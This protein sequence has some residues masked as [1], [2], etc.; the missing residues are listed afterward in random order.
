MAR[1]RR[2]KKPH[3]DLSGLPASRNAYL[4][5]AHGQV[6]CVNFPTRLLLFFLIFGLFLIP[7]IA[8]TAYAAW[9]DSN[10]A[11]RK[12]ITID[13][14]QIV[15]GPHTD[16]PVLIS[17]TDTDLSAARADGWD[18]LFTLD[19]GTSKLSHEI[20]KFDNGT[21]E[22]V[23]WVKIP[24]PGLTN[25]SDFTLYLYYGYATVPA[26]Q[27]D[28][29]NVWSNGY[30]GVWHLDETPN[31]GTA[32][33]HDD[34]TGNVLNN[35]GTPQNFQDGD[36]GTTS[37]TG[38]IA[39]ADRFANQVDDA[40]SVA[41]NAGQTPSGDMSFS[42]WVNIDA[43]PNSMMFMQKNH[44]T[45]PWFAYQLYLNSSGW[46]FM[47]WVNSGGTEYN[48]YLNSPLSTGGWHYL[49]GMLDGTTVR[50]YIDGSDLGTITATTTGTILDADSSL[51]LG[52][53]EGFNNSPNGRMD[54]I[55][56][57]SAA[58][59]ADWIQTEYNNQFDPGVGG[60]LRSLGSEEASWYDINWL[61][62]KA[63][64]LGGS[65]FCQTVNNFPVPITL[66][67]DTDLQSYARADGYDLLFTLDDGTSKVPHEIEVFTKTGGDL[68]AWV[69]LDIVNGV[70]QTLYMYYGNAGASDQ[71]DTA[72]VWDANFVGVWH[73]EEQVTDNTTGGTH[74]D[75]TGAHDGTQTNNGPIAG[76]IAG[77][78]DFD[79]SGDFIQIADN[80]ALSFGNGGTDSAFSVSAWIQGDT[81]SAE[82]VGKNWLP[83]HGGEWDFWIHSDGHLGL[84]LDD[85][86]RD[87]I[88]Q[89]TVATVSGS[90]QHVMA[91]YDGSNTSVGINLYIDGVAQALILDN[92]G[93]Y[94]GM[95][96]TTAPVTIG[97][98]DGGG[99]SYDVDG[100]IDEV[101]ISNIVR[102]PAWIQA[103]V[104]TAGGVVG[105]TGP[106]DYP[107]VTSAVAE[108]AP[109]TVG[110]GST[111]NTFTYDILPTVGVNDTGVNQVVITA[112]A[113]YANLNVT[114]VSLG[115]TSKSLNCLS[116]V[117]GQYC[118]S[119]AGQDITVTLG[120]QGGN[121]Q[122]IQVVFDADA[123]GAPGSAS[124]T[125]TVDDTATPVPAQAATAGNADGDGAD[126][127]SQTV[128]VNA[129]AALSG[130]VTDDSETEIRAGGSTLILTLTG[131]TWVAAGGV[132]DAQR[133]NIIDGLDSAQAEATGWDAV[134]KAGISVD[135]VVRTSDTVVTVTLP[136]F[137]TYDITA[138]ETITATIPATAVT[139]GSAIV[140][141]PNFYV[142]IDNSWY[143]S[144]WLYRK[145][146]I[147]D[148]TNFC[149]TVNAFPVP[150]ILSGDADLQ[151]DA[152]ADG[153]DI[154]FTADDGVT[155]LPH[156]I[157]TFTKASGDLVAWVKLD[158][159]AGVD[160]TLYMYYGNTGAG[161]QQDTANV[162]DANFLGV[163][164]LA[165]DVVDEGT[166]GSHSD[167]TSPNY[168][169][170]QNN[171]ER[172]TGKIGFGQY[173]DG[174][175]DYIQVSNDFAPVDVTFSCWVKIGV[176]GEWFLNKYESTSNGWGLKSISDGGGSVQIREDIGGGNVGVY[177]TVIGTTEYHNVVAV[178][179][180]LEMKLYVDGGLVGSGTNSDGTLADFSGNLF[181]GA[182]RS[183]N[184]Y[185]DGSVDEVR[186]SNIARSPVWIEAE[187]CTAGG[188]VG[189]TGPTQSSAV[190]SAVAEIAPNTVDAGSIGNAFTYDILPTVGASDTGV[191]QVVITAP[192]SYANMSVTTVSLGGTGKIASCPSPAAG[193]Y[194]A[195]ITGQDI[196]VTLGDQGGNGQVI[197]VV[198]DADAPGSTGS[199]DFTSTVD[200]TATAVAAQAVTAGNA[201]G[202]AGDNNSQAVTVNP[203]A[204]LTGTV[205]DDEE[206]D[207][208]IGGSTIILTLTGDTWVADDG[209]F[210]AERQ[211]IRDGIDSAQA[212]ATGWDAVVKT[213]ISVDDVVRTS[214][215]VVTITLPAI[216]AYDITA[217]ETITA[218]IPATAVA[219]GSPIVAAPT[220]DVSV[221]SATAALSGT[222]ADDTE[223][224]IRAG[225]STI[226]LTLTDDTWVAAGGTFDAERQ[227]IR[228]GI[229][230]AQA[231]ATGWDAVVKTGISV[232]DV[233]RTS[234]TVVTITLPAIVAYD[235]TATE[236]I[237]ATIPATA[238]SGGSPIVALPSVYVTPSTPWYDTAWPYRKAVILDG[239]D[240]CK[241]VNGFPVPVI[242]TGDADLQ[243]EARADGFDILFTTEDGVTKL[244][245]EIETFTKASGDLT[246]WV[247][248]DITAGVDETLYMYYGNAGATDQQDK[249]NVWD[250]DFV[251]VWHLDEDG[252][253]TADEF[254]DSSGS[255]NHG[256]GGSGDSGKTPAK[257]T[258]GQIGNAQ[259]FDGIDNFIDVGTMGNFGSTLTDATYAFWIKTTQTTQA[260][261]LGTYND[262]TTTAVSM[263]LN[264]ENNG[265]AA[266][267]KLSNHLR[268]E[269]VMELE[270]SAVAAAF[271]D[272]GWHQVTII[273]RGPTNVVEIYLDG[274]SLSVSISEAQTPDN[275]VDFT[276]GAR[277]ESCHLSHNLCCLF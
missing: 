227:N 271:N 252:N 149:T 102:S 145:V 6:F 244:P 108:I 18:L 186:I 148:G 257:T 126:N 30:I 276:Y 28:A 103:E 33:G 110:A 181:I 112:P 91:T 78:Q 232:D 237:T 179:D 26:D 44:G 151:A 82:I 80:D 99:T 147:L 255:G 245:H 22:L 153:F 194:C 274:S 229:D 202:D 124:F 137:A 242:L 59:S 38:L 150:V 198:F 235:I 105:G 68:T 267:D 230:S 69:K 152:Q 215:T 264:T 50:I 190:T 143:D 263:Q 175:D 58:R 20:E 221:S 139:G 94:D 231:E 239:L 161:D 136:A 156:E 34:S 192:A 157:E 174:T 176:G 42:A 216:A 27:Q 266:V 122:V 272:G 92:D 211:N 37:A 199:A 225:G 217:T 45:P 8:S 49:V 11:Y 84:T 19:D 166:G 206:L 261:A 219:S 204:A 113:G 159:T 111:G 184:N 163:W 114:A 95:S 135:D 9:Y 127:N 70:N 200:D 93:V 168:D 269:D 118:A 90:W 74:D 76:K 260:V 228:D 160:Q 196:T 4:V 123:P 189:G 251:G 115:G 208:R 146:V 15:G 253:G 234:D 259:V 129:T 52:N 54:E 10:W 162:W 193:E 250:T 220:F 7:Q 106:P 67:G 185:F 222:V 155:K 79:G 1:N 55:R 21:G 188:V 223:V 17:I 197:Q 48:A 120:D 2:T 83:A 213:G 116:P 164:H 131:D 81:A 3:F 180:S 207:I 29:T 39:G 61:Y 144:N 66:S 154:L 51:T 89:E 224:D 65:N 191:N 270:G 96:N 25:G 173:F 107:A 256:Q 98:F 12:A 36:G 187:V 40:I 246:A 5:A 130:T 62:R 77:A 71:Q 165:E 171:N 101:R 16:F 212:E 265:S 142:T 268:D 75:S 100:Q 158:I 47:A 205:T 167:S 182:R 214:D 46:P 64:N 177:D 262:G 14:S 60:F 56:L 87:T 53:T 141:A 73:L 254:E 275:F 63:V 43:I 104:C 210:D 133:Q 201:D 277:Q 218:T 238:V 57:A 97:T 88:G 172:T 72:N 209:T 119:I 240:F 86:N 32:G 13:G 247:K 31:D 140:A 132:F 138:T 117:A 248:L 195:S 109:N 243:A 170:T 183:T 226:I 169:G 236:T 128:A 24:A 35:D 125:S 41:D 23:A 249:A 134:V 273:N 233:V 85:S 203:A 258:S 241:S 178:M 121:G